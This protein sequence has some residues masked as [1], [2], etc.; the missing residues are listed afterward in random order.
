MSFNEFER[1]RQTMDS[2]MSQMD[3]MMRG[4]RGRNRGGGFWDPWNDMDM[5]WDWGLDKW[6]TQQQGLL[7]EGGEPSQALV[8]GQSPEQRMVMSQGQLPILRCRVN[9]EDKK[10]QYVVTAEVPG[11]DKQNLH[12]NISDDNILTI[13]G[14]QKKEHVDE[15]KDK[16]YLRVERSFGSVQR[17]LRLPRNI[18]KNQVNASY[19][20]GVLHINVPKT[21][22]SDVKKSNIQIA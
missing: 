9:V 15:A 8:S 10:D 2:F 5:G 11:F 17:S 6:P 14:E 4:G 1:L 7:K 13:S 3:P 21:T 12:V 22:E 16:N 18:D 20:N 19:E